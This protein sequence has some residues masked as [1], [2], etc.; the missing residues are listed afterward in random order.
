MSERQAPT[1]TDLIDQASDW[2]S[3]VSEAKPKKGL[4][5]RFL[6]AVAFVLL[7]VGSI[8]I[9]PVIAGTLFLADT[10]GILPEIAI[11]ATV[12]VL[13]FVFKR[14]SGNLPR[15]AL[16]IDY[17]ACEVRLGAQRADGTFIRERVIGFRDIEQVYV[18]PNP[19]DPALCLRI[20]GEIVSLRFHQADMDSLEA[21]S[22]KIAAARESAL[23]AP[24]RS[25]IQ[26]RIL[27]FEASFREAKQRIRTRIRS[28]S[29]T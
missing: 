10:T 3:T 17:R 26:S 12:L 22:G 15:N 28:R 25:R 20:D 23:R 2:G 18:D 14:K 6:L 1:S 7:A 11:V 5:A 8:L 9:L 24:V 19:I 27:G 4:K 13:A 29:A 21:L 16:Q